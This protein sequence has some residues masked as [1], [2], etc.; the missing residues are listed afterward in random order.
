MTKFLVAHVS[1][2]GFLVLLVQYNAQLFQQTSISLGILWFW[3]S[4]R[5]DVTVGYAKRQELCDP[6]Q[7][8]FTH[9]PSDNVH[10]F[11]R[12]VELRSLHSGC[13]RDVFRCCVRDAGHHH[14]HHQD[15]L[16]SFVLKRI[17]SFVAG[18]SGA[19]FAFFYVRLI[20]GTRPQFR[21]CHD[22]RLSVSNPKWCRPTSIHRLSDLIVLI[23][24]INTRSGSAGD[25]SH[26]LF[27]R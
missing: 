23:T 2:V 5:L 24:H 26:D 10:P 16:T 17:T 18:P 9:V 25:N 14:V 15:A 12:A 8:L 21:S 27:R 19:A 11:P 3:C 1:I 7:C 13:E 22:W 4:R 20:V 6:L